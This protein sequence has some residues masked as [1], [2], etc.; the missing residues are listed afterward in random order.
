MT[1]FSH[2]KTEKSTK[3]TP[4]TKKFTVKTTKPNHKATK[5]LRNDQLLWDLNKKWLKK[6]VG[7]GS[8]EQP[9]EISRLG[10]HLLPS[11]LIMQKVRVIQQKLY[12]LNH[13]KVWTNS[14]KNFYISNIE[15]SNFE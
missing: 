3:K 11:R 9:T 14:K 12:E 1:T 6:H 4:N 2:K 15:I 13:Q 5:K 8:R 10:L 7:Q